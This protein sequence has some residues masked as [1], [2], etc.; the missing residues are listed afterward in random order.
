MFGIGNSLRALTRSPIASALESARRQARRFEEGGAVEA[1][2]QKGAFV[3]PTD[4]DTNALV[5]AIETK[6][7][8]GRRSASNRFEIAQPLVRQKDGRLIVRPECVA[9]LG[10]GDVGRG[11]RILDRIVKDIRERRLL[12]R[13]KQK[14]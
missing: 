5:A 13:I 2:E 4:I 12:A 14:S 3:I 9:R 6:L 11:R 7:R 8:G 1:K 10:G